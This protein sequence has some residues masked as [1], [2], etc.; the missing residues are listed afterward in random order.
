MIN[1]LEDQKIRKNPKALEN[2][3]Q[4][5]YKGISQ[6]DMT[7]QLSVFVRDPI[8]PTNTKGCP[9][10]ATRIKSSLENVKK[11]RTCSY[12]QTPGHYATGCPKR[13]VTVIFID[14]S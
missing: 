12:C 11:K 1:F 6:V 5:P 7:P 2:V 14:S 13:K 9:K 10:N 3:S 4:S 8:A